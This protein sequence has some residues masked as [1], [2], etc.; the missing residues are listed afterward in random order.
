M[1]YFK[2]VTFSFVWNASFINRAQKR[3]A[4]SFLKE[5]RNIAGLL[6]IIASYVFCWPVISALGLVSFY[7]DEPLF[8]TVGGPLVYAFSYLL[9][10]GGVYLAGKKYARA[11]VSH[12][13]GL[14]YTKGGYQGMSPRR[15]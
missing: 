11:L 4:L 1:R 6:L 10:M 15:R 12:S 9:L 3:K 5:P 14:L 7:L 2:K 13:I 8:F